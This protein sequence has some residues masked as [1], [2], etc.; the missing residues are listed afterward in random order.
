LSTR[1]FVET[2]NLPSKHHQRT[3]PQKSVYTDSKQVKTIGKIC[4]LLIKGNSF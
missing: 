3:I 4:A 1:K 2:G